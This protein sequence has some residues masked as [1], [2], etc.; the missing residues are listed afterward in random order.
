MSGKRAFSWLGYYIGFHKN[1]WIC[2]H[3]AAI[4]AIWAYRNQ[5]IFQQKVAA[6][7]FIF[8][9]DLNISLRMYSLE[10]W[11]QDGRKKLRKVLQEMSHFF[12]GFFRIY[13]SG[14]S[15][16][17][18]LIMESIIRLLTKDQERLADLAFMYC[19]HNLISYVG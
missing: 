16:T 9:K 13:Q 1:I 6:V 8:A 3:L 19:W 2:V 4:W 15:E 14:I 12:G 11:E 7:L 5:F 17:E 18:L 10:I